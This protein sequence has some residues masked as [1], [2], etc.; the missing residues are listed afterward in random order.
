MINRQQFYQALCDALTARM[1]TDADVE[2]SSKLHVLL[3]SSW[4]NDMSPEY[5]ECEVTEV[6]SKFR[7]QY[8]PSLKAEYRD[9]KESAGS[10]VGPNVTR[11]CAMLQR[12]P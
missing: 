5:G 11:L 12:F 10:V 6:C 4:P 9:F 7:C 3:P 2:I 1:M 8:A